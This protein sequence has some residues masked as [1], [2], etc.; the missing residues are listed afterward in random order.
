M[1]VLVLEQWYRC[2]TCHPIRGGNAAGGKQHC[3]RWQSAGIACCAQAPGLHRGVPATLTYKA[4]SP[5]STEHQV[6]CAWWL[7]QC[8]Q[9]L[10]FAFS[11]ASSDH[12]TLVQLSANVTWGLIKF[13]ECLYAVWC[14]EFYQ[15]RCRGLCAV[16]D[17]SSWRKLIFRT[18]FKSCCKLHTS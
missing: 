14:A 1:A 12:L 3:P 11:R 10:R 15:R 4:D 8:G 2:T 13:S 6:G 5:S 7:P 9:V 16:V 17:S 18:R